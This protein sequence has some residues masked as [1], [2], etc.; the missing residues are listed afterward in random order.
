MDLQKL[1]NSEQ[2]F[3]RFQNTEFWQKDGK[4]YGVPYLWGANAIAFNRT[5]TGEINSLDALWNPAFKGRIAMRDEA[6]DSVAI[7]ALKLGIENPYDLDEKGLQEVKK[8]L[9]AQKPLLR[10]YWKRAADVSSL[11]GSREVVVTW[12]FLEVV[13]PLRKSGLDIGW[14]WPKEGAIGITQGVAASTE[15]KNIGL[16]QEYA[17]HT[18]S[19]DFGHLMASTTRYAPTS[20]AAVDRFDAQRR[21]LNRWSWVDRGHDVAHVPVE[22]ARGVVLARG[23]R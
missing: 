6:E 16:V 15:T 22:V 5:E 1:P 20:K 12:S 4:S 23:P 14:V 11:L 17:N 3:P 18:L 9:I 10:T 21:A 2:L 7:A 8:L 19:A 13:A